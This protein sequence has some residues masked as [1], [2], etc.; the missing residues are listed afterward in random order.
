MRFLSLVCLLASFVLIGG[1]D[2]SKSST[3]SPSTTP[4]T[5]KAVNEPDN[6]PAPA[7]KPAAA[8]SAPATQASA[9]PIN[10]F[11]AVEHDDKVDPKVTTTYQG[12]VIGFCCEDCIPKFNKEP[13]KYMASLK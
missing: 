7:T 3:P 12:K 5:D 6:E 1:C 8:T 4:P 2:Q 9:K 13:E 11:C 10:Q